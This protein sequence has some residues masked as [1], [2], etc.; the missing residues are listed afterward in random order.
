M[1]QDKKNELTFQVEQAD[2]STEAWKSHLLR[3]INQD[4][5]RIEILNSL[6]NTSVL[7]LRLGHEI[8]SQKVL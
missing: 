8:H 1:S 7:G 4:E 3:S 5:A 2:K 6:D